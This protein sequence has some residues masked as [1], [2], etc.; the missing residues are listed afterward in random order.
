MDV[1]MLEAR[2]SAVYLRPGVTSIFEW[3]TRVLGSRL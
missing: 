2:V 3:P 1:C